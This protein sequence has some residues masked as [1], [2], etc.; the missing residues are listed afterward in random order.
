MLH[1]PSGCIRVFFLS[2]IVNIRGDKIQEWSINREHCNERHSSWNW[3]VQHRPPLPIGVSIDAPSPNVHQTFGL[4]VS[5]QAPICVDSVESSVKTFSSAA[6][7]LFH[8][9][10]V[11]FFALTSAKSLYEVSDNWVHRMSS[12]HTEFLE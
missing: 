1:L 5:E 8:I 10:R 9:V 12:I 2:D 3:S 11:V 7:H 6:F 4:V